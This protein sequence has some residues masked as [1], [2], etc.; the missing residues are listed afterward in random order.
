ML[1]WKSRLM[2]LLALAAV[3]AVAFGENLFS[4]AHNFGW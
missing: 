1:E 2:I 3:F 4:A